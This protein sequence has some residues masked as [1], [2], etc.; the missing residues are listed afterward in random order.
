MRMTRPIARRQS[1]RAFTIVEL[2]VVISII[3]LLLAVISVGIVQA[4]KTARQTKALSNLKQVAVAWTQYA[5]QND[6]RALPGFM[7]DA[8]QATFRIKVRDRDGNRVPEQFCRTYPFRLLPFLEHDRSLMYDY[9]AD[10]EQTSLIP[11]DEIAANPAFGYN[12]YYIGGWW[13][14][15]PGQTEEGPTG[16]R[17]RFSGTGYFRAPGQLVQRQEMVARTLAQIQRP[18]DM[19][20]FG[21]SFAAQPGFF[22]NPD[23]LARGSA[24]IVP[25]RRAT[26]EIWAASDGT[27]FNTMP[28]PGTLTSAEGA[29]QLWAS[30]L[31]SQAPRTR[32]TAVLTQGGAGMDVFV[33]ESVPLRR[34]KNT[35]PTVRADL[36]TESQGLRDLMN[37]SRWMNNAGY[38]EDPVRFSHPDG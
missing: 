13:T 3:A 19:V 22:K 4:G 38:S 25:S 35:V 34:I 24:W 31:G 30:L 23:E 8:T 17:V 2:L 11:Q 1:P 9:L 16:P 36:S 10:Y 37:Q 12:A 21:S 33:A 32:Q 5:N 28:A 14:T 26:T 29:G 7:D 15:A 18:S 6:D 27:S 20:V